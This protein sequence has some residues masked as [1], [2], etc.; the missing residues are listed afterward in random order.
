[1]RKYEV[2][3]VG[4]MQPRAKKNTQLPSAAAIPA[5]FNIIIYSVEHYR[6][7]PGTLA[8]EDLA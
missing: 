8:L 5:L 7:S 6:N 3:K 1:V 4:I 2:A